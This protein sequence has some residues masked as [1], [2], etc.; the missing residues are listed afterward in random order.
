MN[1]SRTDDKSREL[2]VI[3]PG[4]IGDT[5]LTF[6]VLSALRATLPST[7]LTLV[8][9]AQV[10]PLARW[11]GVADAVEDYADLRW[12]ALFA[13]GGLDHMGLGPRLRQ[14]ER[15]VCW[16]T[17][18]E[19]LV[20]RNLREAGVTAVTVR[21]GRPPAG[22]GVHVASYLAQTLGLVFDVARAVASCYR[23]PSAVLE[24]ELPLFNAAPLV[25]HPGSGSALK[26]WP[27]SRFAAVV[28]WAWARDWP[29]LVLAGPADHGQL[30]ALLGALPAPLP[31]T[32]KVL[33]D[34]PLLR[35]AAQ[36]QRARCYLGNDSGLSHLAGLLGVPTV[37]LFGPSNPA[38]WRPL[39]PAVVTVQSQPLD[40][41]AVDVVVRH[42]AQLESTMARDWGR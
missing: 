42:I 8:G 29:V 35:V 9:N 17:D 18:A 11:L 3:R 36:I 24:Q 20:E 10:L 30:A 23:L 32:I 14:A 28:R 37:A 4:A 1:V 27:A 19:G 26:C 7:R 6:P 16:L 38:V 22:A 12:S 39:G 5:L 21:P 41:L 34:L 40:Q 2:L 13:E 15:V 25:I 33:V 31:D